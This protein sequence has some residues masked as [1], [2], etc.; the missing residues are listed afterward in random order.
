MG[1]DGQNQAQKV[2]EVSAM[3]RRGGKPR[4]FKQK[5]F[6]ELAVFI[7]MNYFRHRLEE[8]SHPQLKL[9]FVDLGSHEALLVNLEIKLLGKALFIS[10]LLYSNTYRAL[11][12]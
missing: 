11:R 8:H 1:E 3:G 10:K 6:D 5:Q 12:L 4:K 7:V 9:L 2:I